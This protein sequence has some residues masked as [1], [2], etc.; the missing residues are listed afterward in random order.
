MRIEPIGF[1]H[2][3]VVEP[4][5]HDWASVTSEVRIEPEFRTGLRGLETFSHVVVL[6]LLHRA[7]F[8]KEEHLLRHP[9]ERADLPLLG[10]FAQ[11][12]RHRPNPIGL[13][14]VLIE[15]VTDTSV[16]VRGLDAL[17][18]TPVID[19]KPHV[20]V[21]DAPS[22]SRHPEWVDRLFADYF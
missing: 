11:R 20:P 6:F 15:K 5:D 18:G 16:H 14:T 13:S 7:G 10:I 17:D 12:A 1:V 4:Q 21:F 2:T 22:G 19:L 8:S 3:L 9:R